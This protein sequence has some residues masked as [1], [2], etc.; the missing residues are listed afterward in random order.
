MIRRPPAGQR[1]LFP[2]PPSALP[3]APQA[4]AAEPASPPTPNAHTPQ[5]EIFHGD[6]LP[7]LATFADA[8][9]DLI[10]ID[11]PFNTG[12]TQARTRIRTERAEDGDRVGFQGRTYRTT[13]LGSSAFADRFDDYLRFLEPRLEQAHRL[14][15]SHGS[16]FLHLDYHEVHYAKVM[17]DGIFGRDSFINEIIWAYDY[18]ARATK[19]WSP[20]HDN[21]LWYAKD[22]GAYCF[23]YEQIDRIPYLAPALVGAEKAARGKTPTDTWWH[24]IVSPTGKERTGYPTQKPLGVLSRIVRVHSRPGDRLLDFFAGSG[25]FGEAGA[26]LGRGV[27]LIDDNPE[28]IAVMRGRFAGLST[29]FR[30]AGVGRD[31]HA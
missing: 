29:A 19:R 3:A 6:N 12:H 5:I 20:K 10:Y 13:V 26:R 17:L 16:L 15:A 2:L 18:G 25:T 21:I 1:S 24:T 11:P 14:L 31:E 28:A 27:V 7:I 22:P 30:E 23:N 8:S 9:F 4:A